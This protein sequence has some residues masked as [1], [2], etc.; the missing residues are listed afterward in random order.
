MKLI[1]KVDDTK[2]SMG[3]QPHITGTGVHN[4]KP[5][6]KRTRQ[7]SNSYAIKDSKGE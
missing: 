5:K 6:R 3:H 2:I 1:I 7:S 4:N